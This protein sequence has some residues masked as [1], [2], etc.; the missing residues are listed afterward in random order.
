[1]ILIDTG[2]SCL[3]AKLSDRLQFTQKIGT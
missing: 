1:M 2:Y 3:F